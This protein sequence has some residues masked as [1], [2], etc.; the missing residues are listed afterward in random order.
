MQPFLV[1]ALFEGA[2]I[3]VLLEEDNFEVGGEEAVEYLV[4]LHRCRCT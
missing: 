1:V 3:I 4:D 2:Q